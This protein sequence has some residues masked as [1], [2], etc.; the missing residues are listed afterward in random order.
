[1]T[2]ISCWW[3]GV[4]PDDIVEITYFGGRLDR[5]PNW[6]A[7]DHPHAEKPPTADE[8]FDQVMLRPGGSLA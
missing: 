6:P 4:E 3:C 8:M 5:I 7:G 1:M 2:E